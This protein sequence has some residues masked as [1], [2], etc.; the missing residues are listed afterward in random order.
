MVVSN[1]MFDFLDLAILGHQVGFILVLGDVDASPSFAQI[2]NNSLP[3][4]FVGICCKQLWLGHADV[5][6]GLAR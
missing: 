5:S 3:T 2:A 1:D 4:C 6:S